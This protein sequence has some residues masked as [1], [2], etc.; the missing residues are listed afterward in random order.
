MPKPPMEADAGCKYLPT[1]DEIKERARK[2]REEGYV[3]DRG[4]PI[5]P[6]PE[7]KRSTRQEPEPVEVQEVR[8]FHLAN[9][10]VI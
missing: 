3:N 9:S 4:Q 8:G 10:N 5:E 1:E 6:W 7:S 2:V